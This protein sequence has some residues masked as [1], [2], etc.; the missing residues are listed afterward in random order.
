M[1][2][3]NNATLDTLVAGDSDVFYDN[4]ARSLSLAARW[5]HCLSVIYDTLFCFLCYGGGCEDRRVMAMIVI[6]THIMKW[7]WREDNIKKTSFDIFL[8]LI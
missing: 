7:C 2:T 8:I 4:D 3:V 5:T 6:K 1:M